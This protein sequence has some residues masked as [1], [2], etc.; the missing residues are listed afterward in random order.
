MLSQSLDNDA[1][2]LS[3]DACP[4]ILWIAGPDGRTD[5]CNQRSADHLG[6]PAQQI[7]GFA[8]FKLV[9]PEDAP[10]VQSAWF[11]AVR[12]GTPYQ[13]EFRIRTNKGQ[14][15]WQAAHALP[16][17]GQGGETQGWLGTCADIHEQKVAFL[18]LKRAAEEIA[19]QAK[20]LDRT[21]EAITV[22]DLDGKILFWN[23]GAERM[24][25]WT[26]AEAVGQNLTTLPCGE[27]AR[28]DAALSATL[29]KG[30]WEGELKHITKDGRMLAVAARWSLLCD[31]EGHPKSILAVSTDITE[32][33]KIESQLLRFQRMNSIGTLAGGIAHDLNNVLAPIMMSIELL[34]GAVDPA[35][36][37]LL[38]TIETSAKR[39]AGLVRQ[40]LTFA[41]GVE[42]NRIDVQPSHLLQEVAYIIKNTFPKNI[43]LELVT[44]KDAW[45]ILGDPTQLHQALLNLCV[46]ARDAMAGGGT[47]TI[48]VENSQLE[49]QHAALNPQVKTGPCVVFTVTDSGKGIPPEIVDRVFEPFFTTKDSG[50]GTGIGLTTV[51]SIVKSHGGVVNLYSE[52]GK[53]TSFRIH[54]PA[55]VSNET[56]EV[57][58][59][60]ESLPRG[61]G[62]WILIVDDEPS[63]LDVARRT[64]E[65]FGY[66]VMVANDGSDAL[67]I[68]TRNQKKIALVITDM[69]MPEAD[70]GVLIHGLLAI[71]PELKIVASSGLSAA[72][73]DQIEAI[74]VKHFLS[75][76]YT[77]QILVK[78]V[79]EVLVPERGTM[80]WLPHSLTRRT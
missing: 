23:K 24:Y 21:E 48:S 72:N 53:G 79:R 75:K 57:R 20:I 68:Y 65:A 80:Q 78:T 37:E 35:S 51:L 66:R 8:W 28:G 22:R 5:Y 39:A 64:L 11:D 16:I 45:P 25:G 77:A 42:G 13:I 19:D 52:V 69:L 46:N 47:L 40:I 33:R 49:E 6:V 2:R 74:G 26:S 58:T 34:K 9:H 14:Y 38:G 55:R 61:N 60:S 71:N 3:A 76:P 12:L 7:H 70:G 56:A 59:V 29:K 4:H 31:D 10:R 36:E 63:I 54:I 32:K 67:E 17:R 41:R 50:K 73:R 62:E 44:P 1:Y 15:R 30:E 18:E 27:V 43:K